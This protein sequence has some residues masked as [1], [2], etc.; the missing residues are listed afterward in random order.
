MNKISRDLLNKSEKI[1]IN[2]FKSNIM[3]K[4]LQNAE[5]KKSD[6]KIALKIV[7]LIEILSTKALETNNF[8]QILKTY[9]VYYESE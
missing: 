6:T 2:V 1:M 9:L 8:T 7:C 4:L 3:F 5:E